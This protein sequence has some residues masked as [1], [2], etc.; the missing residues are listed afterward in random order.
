[1][2]KPIH[3]CTT[4]LSGLYRAIQMVIVLC[5]FA[6]PGVVFGGQDHEFEQLKCSPG[7]AIVLHQVLDWDG[8]GD[9]ELL[10]IAEKAY[11][12]KNRTRKRIQKCA[13]VYEL[14]GSGELKPASFWRI[15]SNVTAVSVAQ[16]AAG[17]PYEIFCF[18]DVGLS[19]LAISP[20]RP[21]RQLVAEP[22][23]LAF[24]GRSDMV[25]YDGCLDINGDSL[26]DIIYPTPGGY[27][28]YLQHEG[29][30]LRFAKGAELEAAHPTRLG[31]GWYNLLWYS[32]SLPVL[33]AVDVNNDGLLDLVSFPQEESLVFL[34]LPDGTY[35][36]WA[37]ASKRSAADD[38]VIRVEV[39]E[40][41]DIDGDGLTDMIATQI[42]GDFGLLESLKTKI[43][44]KFGKKNTLLFEQPFTQSILRK[45]VSVVPEFSD[46]N[47]DRRLDMLLSSVRTDLMT[48][49]L[50]WLQDEVD[51]YYEA[52]YY[53]N[54]R[55]AYYDNPDFKHSIVHNLGK[56]SPEKS[57]PRLFLAHDV[58]LDKRRDMIRYD[59]SGKLYIFPGQQGNG[60]SF[61]KDPGW[62]FQVQ[63]EDKVNADEIYVYPQ[64][65]RSRTGAEILVLDAANNEIHLIVRRQP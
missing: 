31:E 27:Q 9:H 4:S 40:L 8:D 11:V 44:F 29:D 34:R 5:C 56:L 54:R 22:S 28:V 58:N 10:I 46:L 43:R 1:M 50:S 48:N 49:A 59:S 23:F 16:P 21:A 60:L 52:F 51:I 32:S 7:G 62:T 65:V 61:A 39:F 63:P 20:A 42:F 6:A 53:Q 17:K 64:P 37:S 33:C 2:S 47:G 57:M 13:L 14:D 45:G 55:K 25:R 24:P 18:S 36:R 38:S 41:A 35:Q 15:P 19:T 30:E 12:L 26:L 3:T